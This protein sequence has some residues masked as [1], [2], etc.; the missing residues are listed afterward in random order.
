MFSQDQFSHLFLLISLIFGEMALCWLNSYGTL[1]LTRACFV[2]LCRA[3]WNSLLLSI[4]I[5]MIW[6]GSILLSFPRETSVDYS[7]TVIVRCGTLLLLFPALTSLT[8]PFCIATSIPMLSQALHG[9]NRASF[10]GLWTPLLKVFLFPSY[11]VR[12][13]F[14]LKR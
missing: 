2:L 11:Q 7:A 6:M 1:E 4:L 13:Q 14:D 3:Q 5:S 10:E 8:V 9:A 12:L